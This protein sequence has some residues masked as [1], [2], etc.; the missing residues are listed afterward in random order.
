MQRYPMEDN[1]SEIEEEG[2][3]ETNGRQTTHGEH[4]MKYLSKAVP[5]DTR[6]EASRN[7]LGWRVGVVLIHTE[8]PLG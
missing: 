7:P 5:T 6:T 2:R 4:A 3:S 1:V 8:V